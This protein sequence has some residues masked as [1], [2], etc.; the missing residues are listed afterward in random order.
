MSNFIEFDEEKKVIKSINLDDFSVED[1]KEYIS[2]LSYE[3]KRAEEEIEKKS[4]SL[5]ITPYEA[6]I[7]ASLIEEEAQLAEERP[8]ISRVIYNRLQRG[9]RLGV[10]ATSRYA[11]GKTSGQELTISDLEYDSPW[12]TRVSLGLPPTA[13]SGPGRASIQAALNPVE[14]DWLYYVRTDQN[15]VVGA[16]T[17][18]TTADDFQKAR[19]ICVNKDLG[20]G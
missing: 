11:V 1:L 12:N 17:F 9:W 2:N 14:G 6:L 13:I 4:Q 15:G 3:I 18:A 7:I 19:K 16:H 8:M 20:C 5:G 10:D